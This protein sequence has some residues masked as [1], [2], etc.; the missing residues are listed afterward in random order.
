MASGANKL[1]EQLINAMIY[2]ESGNALGVASVDMPQIQSVTNSVSGAGIAGEV[3]SPVLGHFQSM[4]MS[5]KWRTVT[6][7][8]AKLCQQRAHQVDV[9]G[10]QQ[11]TDVASGEY[12]TVP[13]RATM[14]IVP[15]SFSLGTFQPSS[16]TE[17][18][19]E[20]EVIYLKLFV[21]G[22]EVAEIDKYNFIA[23]F[24]DVDLLASVRSDLGLN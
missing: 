12:M 6:S 14:K 11:V 23:K 9:R 7:E 16:S 21:D 15:K 5:L 22:K 10:S 1:P 24:G 18:E 4:T 8:A 17:T 2:D 20:F 19:Q 13:V 3:D